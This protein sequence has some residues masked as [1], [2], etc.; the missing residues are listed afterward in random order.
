MVSA[1]E[2]VVIHLSPSAV[3]GPMR[4]KE[5]AE[6]P[7]TRDSWTSSSET[8][9]P[10]GRRLSRD[11]HPCGKA[12]AGVATTRLIAGGIQYYSA[13]VDVVDVVDVASAKGTTLSVRYQNN[14]QQPDAWYN[15]IAVLILNPTPRQTTSATCDIQLCSIARLLLIS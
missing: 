15:I 1:T 4:P 10:Y 14:I 7:W 12:P 6:E 5:N 8:S 3:G 9:M 11:K 13:A 2:A